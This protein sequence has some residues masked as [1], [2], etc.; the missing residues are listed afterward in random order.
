MRVVEHR[1]KATVRAAER[2]L[3]AI[4]GLG[5]PR[6]LFCYAANACIARH[7]GL[8]LRIVQEAMHLLSEHGHIAI[9]LHCKG[10]YRRRIV[11]LDHPDAADLIAR[12]PGYRLHHD[13]VNGH[14]YLERTG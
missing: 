2:V 3:L 5:D 13:Q 10:N 11:I 7:T 14:N 8:R 6:G 12:T 4:Y 9:L 1:S